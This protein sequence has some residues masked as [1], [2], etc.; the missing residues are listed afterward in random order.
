MPRFPLTGRLICLPE[1]SASSHLLALIQPL[2]ISLQV[3]ATLPNKGPAVAAAVSSPPLLRT[4]P[5][6]KEFSRDLRN[7]SGRGDIEIPSASAL[8][9]VLRVYPRWA[10]GGPTA[11]EATTLPDVPAYSVS[12]PLEGSERL[13]SSAY[14]LTVIVERKDILGV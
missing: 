12:S 3:K 6:W 8:K 9:Q 5:L 11:S 7:L 10:L 4:L 13:S 1:V 14:R 2:K